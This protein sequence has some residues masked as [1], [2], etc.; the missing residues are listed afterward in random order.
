MKWGQGRKRACHIAVSPRVWGE[1]ETQTHR[2]NHY[3]TF[4]I[5]QWFHNSNIIFYLYYASPTHFLKTQKTRVNSTSFEAIYSNFRV[6]GAL[7]NNKIFNTFFNNIIVL[8]WYFIELQY[9]TFN[10]SHFIIFSI[11]S[12]SSLFFFSSF[13]PLNRIVANRRFPC[14]HYM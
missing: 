7:F 8:L 2:E 12:L 13:S 3:L 4:P 1:S 9:F 6:L 11:L 14:P 10:I 5:Y